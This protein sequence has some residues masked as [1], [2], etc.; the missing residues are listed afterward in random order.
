MRSTFNYNTYVYEYSYSTQTWKL[1]KTRLLGRFAPIFYF[2]CEHFLYAY[3]Y[4]KRETKKFSKNNYW[5]FKIQFY[6]R[7]IIEVLIIQKRALGPC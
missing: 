2:N 6:G 1:I 7:I 5:I 3:A 4:C